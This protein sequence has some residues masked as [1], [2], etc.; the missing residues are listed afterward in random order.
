MAARYR[1]QSAPVVRLPAAASYDDFFGLAA[2]LNSSVACFWLKQYS[3]TKGA[4]RAD[5]LRASE[6]WEH[7]YEFTSTCL[8]GIAAACPGSR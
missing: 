8:A 6:P 5:Q 4:P 2:S 7:F 1:S 3:Q